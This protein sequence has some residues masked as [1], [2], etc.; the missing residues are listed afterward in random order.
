MEMVRIGHEKVVAFSQAWM[1]MW[2]KWW[3]APLE[4]LRGDW[5]R[6][7]PRVATSLITAGIAPVHRTAVANAKRLTR[8]KR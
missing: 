8:S 6:A 1:A 4:L 5:V 2:M 3:L 7:G